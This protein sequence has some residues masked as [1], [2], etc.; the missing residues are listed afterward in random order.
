[1]AQGNASRWLEWAREIQ[2]IGQ[3]GVFYSQNDFDRQRYSRLID[4]ASEIV[5]E[6]TRHPVE[7]I[8]QVFLAQPGYA[9]PKVD[10]RAAVFRNDQVL[11]VREWSDGLWSLPGGWADVNQPP[12]LMTE[13]EVWEESGFKVKARKMVGVFEA[14]HDREPITVYHAY[15]FVFLCDLVSGKATT[16]NE[17]TAVDFFP[18]DQLPPFSAA[19]TSLRMIEEAYAHLHDPTR[20]AA[21]D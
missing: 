7:E 4:I 9:T 10:V 13:R 2:A 14:N 12:S 5:A 21:F 17:T 11:L 20:A 8:R 6:H 3:T 18:L 15:K 19:R 1:M 16:S